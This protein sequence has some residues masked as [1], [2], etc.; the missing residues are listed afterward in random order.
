MSRQ[1]SS[2]LVAGTASARAT[3]AVTSPPGINPGSRGRKA[4]QQGHADDGGAPGIHHQH[5]VNVA[6][7][8]AAGSAFSLIATTAR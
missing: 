8:T 7:A 3:L 5:I 4:P 2:D 1:H 6:V